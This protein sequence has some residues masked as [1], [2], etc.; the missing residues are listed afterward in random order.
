MKK[1]FFLVALMN[2]N[3][4]LFAQDVDLTKIDHY[5]EKT[6]KEWQ[7]P[8]MTVGIVK[9][10]ELIFSKGYG[11][12]EEG[13]E[14]KPDKNTL[15]AI[16]SNSKAF[17]STLLA[18]LEQEGKISWNDKVVDHLPYF[19]IYDKNISQLVTIKDLLTH[20]VG[21]G[22]FS[23]DCMWYDSNLTTEQIVKRAKYIPQ[24]FEF[25]DGFGYSNVMYITAGALIEK[26]TGKTW[27]ENVQE[28]IL[29][30]LGMDRTIYKLADLE[31]K[32]NWA[33]PYATKNGKNV[34]IRYENWENVA[35]TGGLISSVE[36]LAKWVTFNMNH[37][38][39]KNDTLLSARNRNRIW[40]GWNQFPVNHTS[41]NKLDADFSGYGFG[42][43]VGEHKGKFRVSH[44]GGFGGMLSSIYMLPDEKLA[45]IMLSNDT[46]SPIVAVP[47]YIFDQF[48]DP[49]STKDYS[50]ETLTRFKERS[51]RDTRIQDINNARVTKRAKPSKTLNG[52][53]GDYYSDL[54]GGNIS[55]KEK[56]GQLHLEFEHTPNINATL[57]HWHYDTFQIHWNQVQPWFGFGVVQFEMDTK[58]NITGLRFNVPNNDFFF[59]EFKAKKK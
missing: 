52:Y 7:L 56:N 35:A 49:S 27:G 58:R 51:K 47:N 36:D 25:R 30:P 42:F 16:A 8:S 29:T 38:I 3:W 22:T 2:F 53:V 41:S 18:M 13:K 37:G 15:Y 1:L 39:H 17:T 5:L 20:R 31:K 6:Y 12:L 4:G 54:Y 48:V 46:E 50:A 57:S 26:V 59:E 32:G 14:T 44:T 28:R 45:V 23:G 55:V 34:K 9:D 33:K 10:G 19:E 40:T 11:K 24:A 21:L 43:S